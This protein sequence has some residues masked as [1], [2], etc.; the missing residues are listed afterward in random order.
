MSNATIARNRTVTAGSLWILLALCLMLVAWTPVTV[1]GDAGLNRLEKVEVGSLPGNQVQ[2]VLELARPA[3]QPLSF[4]IDN[5]ARIA[6]DLPGTTNGLPRRSQDIGVGV[7]KSMVAVEAKGRTR[8]VFNLVELVPYETRVSGNRIILTL[9]DEAAVAAQAAAPVAVPA[10]KAGDAEV[11]KADEPAVAPQKAAGPR[12]EDIDFRRG[13][14][15][16]G[17]IL[18]SLSDP[19]TV[20]NM[21]RSGGKIVLDVL[22][23]QLPDE[24]VRRLDVLDF[25]TPVK[26]IDAYS[27]DGNVRVVI[28]AQGDY[29]HLAFQTDNLYVVE[30]APMTREE[31]EQRKREKMGYTGE[32]LSLNFQNIEV[33]SVLQ[34]IADFTGTNMVVS[35]SVT[36]NITLRLQNVPWDQA[37]DIILKTKGLAMRK[38]GDVMLVAPSE[39]IA[40][41]ERMELESQKQ[42]EELAPLY[43]EH[44]QINYA[45][46]EDI[47]SLLRGGDG[48]T[49]LLSERGTVTVD[50]RTNTLLLQDTQ[51]KLEEIRRLVAKLDVPVRQV[52]IESRIVIAS[53]SFAKDL[54]ARFGVGSWR[55]YN[56]QVGDNDSSQVTT[57]LGGGM[58]GDMSQDGTLGTIIA[59]PSDSDPPIE[60]LTTD[61]R[62]TNPAGAINLLI[63]RFGREFLRL[64]LSA[65]Q[66][67]GR[68]EVI[69]SP[70]VITSNQKE[71]EIVQ[72]VEIPYLQAASSGATS[73]QFKQ[74]VLGLTV[75]PQITPDD[76][77]IMDL[78]VRKDNVG[79]VFN[80]VPSINTRSVETQ[81]LVEN[82]ETVVLGGIY[83]RTKQH[84]RDSVPLLGSIPVVGALFRQNRDVDDKQEL[85]IFVT[86][87]IVKGSLDIDY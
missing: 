44:I 81:V 11:A 77:I 30:I 46:A 42:I 20:V 73:V 63:G 29:D 1:A 85:L 86:P 35:D 21:S 12:V 55:G 58:P 32:R 72:G 15:G 18:V 59:N 34:L 2:V 10:A 53:D 71:A 39:E 26:T 4:T 70:R 19:K 45:K 37:L 76:R 80:G 87:K 78:L 66:A 5:P 16:E 57:I 67:E 61:L 43:S 54:G 28:D 60:A 38:K 25:A 27:K 74:A 22:N 48:G 79:E 3:P 8:V 82:G 41:R 62:V 33:R 40:A 6:L 47:A 23:A 64:E 52:L 9:K 7:A 56:P 69:S 50:Q 83:E 68:G 51:D 31:L 65:M 14:K 84:E 13:E 36:G 24:L 75:T 49:A 17:R